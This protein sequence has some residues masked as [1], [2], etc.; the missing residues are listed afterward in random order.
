M[1]DKL[2]DRGPDGGGGGGGTVGGSGGLEA[3][4]D[5]EA[6]FEAPLAFTNGHPVPTITRFLVLV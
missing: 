2:R 6:E 4:A 3:D 5:V 1:F